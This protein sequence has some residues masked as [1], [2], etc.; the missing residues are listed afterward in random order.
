ML[1]RSVTLPF[2]SSKLAAAD[3]SRTDALVVARLAGRD[4]VCVAGQQPFNKETP[5]LFVEQSVLFDSLFCLGC[6]E[7]NGGCNV[8]M[9]CHRDGR[10]RCFRIAADVR[11]RRGRRIGE[12]AFEIQQRD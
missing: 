11:S 12:R 10:T 6:P 1:F 9:P 3:L 8:Q 7:P 2:F 4:H 5:S